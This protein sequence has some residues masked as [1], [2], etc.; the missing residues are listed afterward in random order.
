MNK[1]I[2]TQNNIRIHYDLSK[3]FQPKGAIVFL[4]GMGGSLT[5]FDPIRKLLEEEGYSTVAIDIRG[6]GKSG[7][8]TNKD[9]YTLEHLASD[10][11]EVLETE[12]IDDFILIGHCFGGIVAMAVTQK[13]QKRIKKLILIDTNFEAPAW[14]KTISKIPGFHFLMNFFIM[15]M[16]KWYIDETIDYQKFSGGGDYNIPRIISDIFHTSLK[17]YLL[18]SKTLLTLDMRPVLTNFSLPV[19]IIQGEK[20]TVYSPKVAEKL[21]TLLPESELVYVKNANHI[22]VITLYQEV[23]EI[24]SSSLKK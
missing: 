19:L 6:Q 7:R 10:V 9:A 5:A 20:D 18:L 1:D 13:I 16:P 15:L 24:I 3:N 11:L 12:K 8:P 22:L 14:A 17:T 2:Y 23:Y 4:H 21:Q